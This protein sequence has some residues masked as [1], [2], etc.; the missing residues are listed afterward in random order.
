MSE[1]NHENE[2]VFLPLE[3]LLESWNDVN[4]ILQHTYCNYPELGSNKVWVGLLDKFNKDYTNYLD[5]S[6]DNDFY[7]NYTNE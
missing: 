6:E 3:N 1:I 5:E 7:M 2:V 4:A